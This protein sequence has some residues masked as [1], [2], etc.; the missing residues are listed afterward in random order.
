[1]MYALIEIVSFQIPND[2]GNVPTLPSFAAPVAIKI[3]KHLF[4][5]DMT[6][7]TSYKNIY[8][9]CFKMLNHNIAN[10]FKMSPNPRLIG[11]NMT[12]SIQHI[13]NQ[14][15][16]A[17]G[18]PSRHELLHNET[19]FCLPFHA[20]EAPER[21][22]WCIKQ[23]QEIQVIADNPYTLMQLITNALQLLMASGIF[24]MR[25]FEDWETMPNK[26]YNSLKLFVHGAYARQL[27][28]VRLRT[29]GQQGYLA[30]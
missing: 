12:M 1:M 6:Y 23:C 25:E 30:N 3:A 7:F 20:T 22:F 26:T 2:P 15:E 11:W 4:E 28:A 24:P 21:I 9:A 17:H 13:L 14:L 8:K 19:L 16:L 10:K 18:R 27:A 29:T 5:R